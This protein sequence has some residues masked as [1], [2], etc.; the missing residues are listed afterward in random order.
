MGWQRA[1]VTWRDRVVRVLIVDDHE[2][3]R[4]GI[5]GLLKAEGIEVAGEA[6]DGL[7]ALE[8]V[9]N[10]QPDVV[11]LDI[12]MPRCDG[13]EATRLIKAE[14]PD[15]KIVI[16]TAVEEDENIFEAI[17]S[18][19][20]GYLLKNLRGAQFVSLLKGVERGEAAITSDVASKIL[21]EFSRQAR[22]MRGERDVDELTE[23]E[24]EVLQLVVEGHTN[25]QIGIKLGLSENTVKYHLRHIL[26]KLHLQN[27]AQVVA[28]AMRH[29]LVR[30]QRR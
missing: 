19:A 13:L 29:G 17:K 6:S 20:Q 22:G 25:R 3:F 8:K 7:E 9:R 21:D 12:M 4:D 23:R 2:L 11:L 15:T 24:I 14:M 26:E 27:R 28:Y 18:G 16:L 10:L 1:G 30:D 5:R